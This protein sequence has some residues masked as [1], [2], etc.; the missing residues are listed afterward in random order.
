MIVDF[1]RE[2][3]DREEVDGLRWGVEPICAVLT[4]HGLQIAPSTYYEWKDKLPTRRQERDQALLVEVRRV[5]AAHYGVYGARKV[6]LQL[7][8]WAA[9]RSPV[10]VRAFTD[11][12]PGFD[13]SPWRCAAELVSIAPRV[14]R[15][16][17]WTRGAHRRAQRWTTTRTA[18]WR[19]SSCPW[20]A[21]R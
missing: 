11:A 10:G 20:P 7:G 15:K 9:R 3:A 6:W 14:G 1:I 4:E 19:P 13:H 21:R 12:Q 5:H 16:S 2:H 8:W 18:G 17:G